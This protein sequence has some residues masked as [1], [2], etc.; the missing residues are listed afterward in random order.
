MMD[1]SEEMGGDGTPQQGYGSLMIKA[2]EDLN[3]LYQRV[4]KSINYTNDITT[5]KTDLD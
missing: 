2:S 1:A 3:I 5:I 4:V